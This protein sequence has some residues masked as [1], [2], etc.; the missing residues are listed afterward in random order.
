MADWGTPLRTDIGANVMARLVAVGMDKRL[1]LLVLL[2][3][4]ILLA[5]SLAQL[6][7]QVLP[8]Q[9]SEPM[10]LPRTSLQSTAKVAQPRASDIN[11]I[12][13]WHLFGEIQKVASVPM[14]QMTEAPDTRLNLKLHGL[15]ASS[16][17]SEA[18]AIIADGKGMEEAYAI[19]EELPGNAVLREIYV[20]R[21]ILEH[22]GRLETLRLPK[23]EIVS[24]MVARTATQ[25]T[26]RARGRGRG[27]TQAGT[28]DNAALLR[29]YRDALMSEP[30]TLMN[31]VNA[32]PVTDKATG[33]LK[34]Y[35]IRPGK[36]RKLLGRFGLKSGDVVTGVNGVALDN[37][38]KALE[39]MRDLST[40]SS[41]ILDVE[42][43][44]VMESFAFQ[45][46]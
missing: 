22:R 10:L 29:Q 18:R 40:A 27:T 45:V 7:W 24:A 38:I 33:R 17:P 36:D 35:R 44:G 39:I 11:R 46:E 21:V 12:A 37:P 32:S 5:Q 31:L 3:L 42:R 15:L 14:A 1:P 34:G 25:N 20:D 9:P 23:D 2:L 30:Q 13:Q 16:D 41:V 26:S 6:T 43:N 28:A 19:D 4:I 8:S